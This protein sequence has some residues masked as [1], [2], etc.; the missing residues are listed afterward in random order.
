M[1]NRLSPGHVHA[2]IVSM[3]IQADNRPFIDV[4]AGIVIG[5]DGRILLAQRPPGK[6]YAGWWEFPGGKVEAGESMAQAIAR[7]LAEELGIRV[8]ESTPWVVREHAYEHARVRLHFR[9]VHRW[10]GGPESR[11]GQAFRWCDPASA[12]VQP[13]LP[14]TIP[15]L[16]LLTLPSLY[17][18]SAAGELGEA[19]FLRALD[20]A[21]DHGLGLLQLREPAIS[22]SAFD[23]LFD[24]VLARC[25]AHG[26]RLLVNSHHPRS[27]WTRADGVHWRST[28]LAAR[29]QAHAWVGASCHDVGQLAAASA[30]GADFAVLGPVLPT[31]SHPGAATMGWAGLHG[32]LERT[33]LPVYALG[34]LAPGDLPTAQA[35]GAH[36]VAMISGLFGLPDE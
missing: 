17:G 29:D 9:R 19:R 16:R 6:P 26:A 22:G 11:E 8:L 2:E 20:Q 27:Y 18:I 23:A 24:Q 33:P 15:L 13:L 31:R 7:E 35:S 34:G 32:L 36:G 14:A 3:N 21:L 5:A 28:E 10:E 30:A 12:D 4:A 25:R 1:T